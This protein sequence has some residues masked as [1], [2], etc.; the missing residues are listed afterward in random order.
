MLCGDQSRSACFLVPLLC[1]TIILECFAILSTLEGLISTKC[2]SVFLL[3]RC[4]TS[5]QLS[6]FYSIPIAFELCTWHRGI[7]DLQLKLWLSSIPIKFVLVARV[8]R[9]LLCRCVAAL[10]IL[11]IMLGIILGRELFLWRLALKINRICLSRAITWVF[12]RLRCRIIHE[13]SFYGV[14]AHS[15]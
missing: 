15:K 9:N 6:G 8:L 3:D 1:V 13:W 12:R 11:R 5:G 7:S 2:S 14:H 10:V 4:W